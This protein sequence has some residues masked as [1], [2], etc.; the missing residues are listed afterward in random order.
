MYSTAIVKASG[1]A[2]PRL[3]ETTEVS[4]LKNKMHLDVLNYRNYT[5]EKAK[6][7]KATEESWKNSSSIEETFFT[8]CRPGKY[9]WKNP[10]GE[11]NSEGIY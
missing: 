9:G 7:G 5:P 1:T 10:V 11:T 8:D 4:N 2:L 6:F 3:L